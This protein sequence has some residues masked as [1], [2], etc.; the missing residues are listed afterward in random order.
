MIMLGILIRGAGNAAHSS[1]GP[2]ADFRGSC[3]A[4]LENTALLAGFSQRTVEHTG[5][6][7]FAVGFAVPVQAL[8][9]T[10]AVRA[11]TA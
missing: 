6:A 11:A 5:R 8:E 7:G 4:G 2:L 3:G 1:V 9:M 10:A